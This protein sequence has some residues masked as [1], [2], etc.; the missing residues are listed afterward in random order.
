MGM[1]LWLCLP[2]RPDFVLIFKREKRKTKREK[3][4]GINEKRG[5]CEGYSS[6]CVFQTNQKI[7]TI[8]SK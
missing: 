2:D 4:K 3:L 8:Q 7:G 5:Y 6:G 1:Y